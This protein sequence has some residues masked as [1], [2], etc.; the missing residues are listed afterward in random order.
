MIKTISLLEGVDDNQA[1]KKTVH[2][3]TLCLPFFHL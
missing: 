1:D 3:V 2:S